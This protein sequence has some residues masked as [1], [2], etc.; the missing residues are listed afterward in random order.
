MFPLKEYFF[1]RACIW[2]LI[3]LILII[4]NLLIVN[5]VIIGG[6]KTV[7]DAAPTS[8]SNIIENYR[9]TLIIFFPI[10]FILAY[11]SDRILILIKRRL[12]KKQY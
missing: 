6:N 7:I 9:N 10:L 11:V 8:V 5:P 12:I 4:P 3:Y 2:F 1:T